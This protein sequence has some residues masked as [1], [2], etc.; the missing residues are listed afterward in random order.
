MAQQLVPHSPRRILDIGCGTGEGILALLDIG[1]ETIVALEENFACIKS[2]EMKLLAQ[3]LDVTVLPR[4]GYAEGYD[5]RHDLIIDQESAIMEAPPI[6]LIHADLLLHQVD[7]PLTNFL[8]NVE[9]FDAVTIWLMGTYD[10][11]RTCR[12]L[13]PLNLEDHKDYRLRVQNLAYEVAD[14][15]LKPGG[16]FQ[17]VDRGLVPDTEY[18]RSMLF[19]MHEEQASVTSLKVSDLEYLRYNE[20]TDRG[21]SMTGLVTEN[22]NLTDNGRRAMN[23]MISIKQ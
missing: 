23:S 13:D 14:K 17:T 1:V 6:T 15:L 9:S 19:K 3:G 18:L 8:R 20:P 12:A 5:G 22:P 2:T 7:S 21:V 16:A 4:I 10:M 11:R